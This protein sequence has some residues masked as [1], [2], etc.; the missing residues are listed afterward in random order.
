MKSVGRSRSGSGRDRRRWRPRS[1]TV[2]LLDV[3]TVMALPYVQVG[4]GNFDMCNMM[5]HRLNRTV[6]LLNSGNC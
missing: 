6:Q 2:L 4:K 5:Q 3:E 1:G